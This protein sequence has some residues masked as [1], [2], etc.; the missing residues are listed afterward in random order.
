MGRK[1][2]DKP[3]K[4]KDRSNVDARV[5]KIQ[6]IQPPDKNPWKMDNER[7]IDQFLKFGFRKKVAFGSIKEIRRKKKR[8]RR[9]I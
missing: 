3:K 8:E 2:K 1:N 6:A 9:Y 5:K 7:K 4:I